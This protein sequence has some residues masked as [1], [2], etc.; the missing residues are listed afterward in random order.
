MDPRQACFACL[1]LEPPNLF[2]AALWIAVEH[3]PHLPAAQAL[4]AVDNLAHQVTA[5]LPLL[6]GDA[7]RAQALLRRL[8]ELGFAED[9]DFP[10][11]ARAA[12]L[13]QVLQRRRG[14]PLS[15]ALIALELAR[16]EGIPLVGVNFPGRF[17]LR[18]PGADHLL[19]PTSG[20][21]LYTRDCRDLL[22]RHLGPQVELNASHLLTATAREMLQRLSRNLR[23]LHQ[24]AGAPLA[25]L[26]DAQ[27][28]LEL[29]E[30]S[31][32]DHLARAELYRQLDCPQ[33]ERYDLERALLLSDDAAEQWQ[34]RRRLEAS[35]LPKKAL[36]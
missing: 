8:S 18:V 25:A 9:D 33:A 30:P 27:R 5:G 6:E 24:A 29:G 11:Q 26:K 4:H 36:H 31:V 23:Q 7:E 21:R 13:P 28:V 17:L 20:R 35:A 16:R 22:A 3:E 32:A 14:Q 19:D 15:L 12:L 1:A 10:L 34:L 2:E